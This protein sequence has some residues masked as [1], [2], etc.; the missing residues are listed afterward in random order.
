MTNELHLASTTINN[1]IG[2]KKSL[3]KLSKR[4]IT[5]LEMLKGLVLSKEAK[6]GEAQSYLT[7][8]VEKN[9]EYDK[10]EDDDNKNSLLSLASILGL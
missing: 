10:S 3:S 1:M 4:Q 6:F 8:Y 9:G 7:A 5:T 2:K